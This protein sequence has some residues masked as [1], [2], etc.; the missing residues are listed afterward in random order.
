MAFL[1]GGNVCLW[2]EEHFG[3][4]S[5]S[6]CYAII[7]KFLAY[8]EKADRD[9]IEFILYGILFVYGTLISLYFSKDDLSHVAPYGAMS[10]R[11]STLSFFHEKTCNWFSSLQGLA[12][13]FISNLKISSEDHV[14]FNCKKFFDPRNLKKL[15]S[16]KYRSH[17]ESFSI[18]G[19]VMS[20]EWIIDRLWGWNAW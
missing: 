16:V 12:D 15:K 7:V 10:I 19:Q 14:G 1:F 18:T 4:E 8:L 2:F 3:S 9:K 17:H 20:V 6:Q 13:S 11:P 5:I